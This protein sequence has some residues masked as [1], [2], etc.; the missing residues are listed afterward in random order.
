VLPHVKKDSVIIKLEAL[1]HLVG[2]G[3]I[4]DEQLL[5]FY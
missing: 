3:E 4:L 2:C 1:E 5:P